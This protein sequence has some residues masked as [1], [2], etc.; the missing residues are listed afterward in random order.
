MTST[1]TIAATMQADSQ[2]RWNSAVQISGIRMTIPTPEV[3]PAARISVSTHPVQASG[4]STLTQAGSRLHGSANDAATATSRTILAIIAARDCRPGGS[5]RLISA[6]T[7]T[8]ANGTTLALSTGPR[9]GNPGG[10]PSPRSTAGT[11]EDPMA[12]SSKA[13][14]D[15][16]RNKAAASHD[17]EPQQRDPGTRAHAGVGIYPNLIITPTLQPA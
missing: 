5:A 1:A 11:A 15:H 9:N 16:R 8:T 17:P 2:R 13:V 7:A 10:C 12:T 6:S 4:T 3:V 14:R